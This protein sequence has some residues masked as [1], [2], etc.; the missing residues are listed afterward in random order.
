M[1]NY[2]EY[3][4]MSH[5]FD[6]NNTVLKHTSDCS[7]IFFRRLSSLSSH[8]PLQHA[9]YTSHVWQSYETHPE[10]TFT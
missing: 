1:K 8:P 10:M 9:V 2:D 5:V 4:L 6:I 3:I 7:S